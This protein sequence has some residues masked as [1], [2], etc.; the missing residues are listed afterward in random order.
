MFANKTNLFY[1]GVDVNALFQVYLSL[2][3]HKELQIISQFFI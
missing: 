3:V 2:P 1:L